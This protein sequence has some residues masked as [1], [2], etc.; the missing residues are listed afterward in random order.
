MLK[1]HYSF[2][3]ICCLLSLPGSETPSQ[4]HTLGHL[5]STASNLLFPFVVSV[6]TLTD[7]WIISEIFLLP[8]CGL[9][10]RKRGHLHETAPEEKSVSCKTQAYCSYSG[11]CF[12]SCLV[13]PQQTLAKYCHLLPPKLH[14]GC[15]DPEYVSRAELGFP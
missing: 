6:L 1:V 9:I 15:W 10:Q 12:K 13:S 5:Q 7:H 8:H 14:T 11:L 2:G 3:Q 4:A